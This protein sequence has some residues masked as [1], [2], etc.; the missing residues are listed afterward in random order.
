MTQLDLTILPRQLVAQITPRN[1]HV[2]L[3]IGSRHPPHLHGLLVAGAASSFTVEQFGAFN[4]VRRKRSTAYSSWL[5]DGTELARPIRRQRPSRKVGMVR[6]CRARCIEKPLAT[7]LRAL[8]PGLS[9]TCLPWLAT[10]C[11]P[12]S[13]F[14]SARHKR[15]TLQSRR[16]RA[17]EFCPGVAHRKCQRPSAIAAKG[18][19]SPRCAVLGFAALLLPTKSGSSQACT[20]PKSCQRRR[21]RY[22][23]RAT[24]RRPSSSLCCSL[25]HA[26]TQLCSCSRER[27]N[28]LQC[29][30]LAPLSMPHF[31]GHP[32]CRPKRV[33]LFHLP[34]P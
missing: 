10:R 3:I 8:R 34:Q 28:A 6:A 24:T 15:M 19:G 27:S 13:A 23:L 31:E 30:P 1:R 33:E 32:G 18:K 29:A 9:P 26:C 5:H 21:Q 12:S 2:N 20:A 25:E 22:R 16:D 4:I 7:L 14:Q 11:L 17:T